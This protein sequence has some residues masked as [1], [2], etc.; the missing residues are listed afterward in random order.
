[1]FSEITLISTLL[2]PTGKT[3]QDGRFERNLDP[4]TFITHLISD[5]IVLT[6]EDLASKAD[7]QGLAPGRLL[8]GY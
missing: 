5:V 4:G 6:L 7:K 3:S 8:S 2:S 1:M